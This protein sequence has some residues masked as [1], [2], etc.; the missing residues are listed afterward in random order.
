M[1]CAGLPP[2]TVQA[3]TSL[4]TTA[5]D[6]MTALSPMVTPGLIT[7]RPPIHTLWPIVTGLPYSPAAITRI[8]VQRMSGGINM[9]ARR[10]HTVIANMDRADVEH[11][12]VKIGVKTGAEKNIITIVAAKAWL[13][14]RIAGAS[15]QLGQNMLTLFLGHPGRNDYNGATTVWRAGDRREALGR[16]I[17]RAHRRSFCVFLHSWV[18]LIPD[19]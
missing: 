19:C 6:A 5:P 7:A 2:T 12:A 10:Q 3:G 9:D 18:F 4:V 1:I 13:D 17:N 8:G 15:E 11:H 14:I 16:Q